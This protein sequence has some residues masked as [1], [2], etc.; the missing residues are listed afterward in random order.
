MSANNSS[1]TLVHILALFTGLIGPL[2]FLLASEDGGVKE[3]AKNALNWQISLLIYMFASAVLM[4]ILVGFL[5]ALV[6]FVLDVVF[7]IMAA[8]KANRNEL[9][10]YPL[11]IP[12]IK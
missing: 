12:F 7:C 9:W 2:I 3:H 4:L 8:V 5:L 11:A 10:D 1:K 6:V